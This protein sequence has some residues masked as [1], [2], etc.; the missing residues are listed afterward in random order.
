MIKIY[1]QRGTNRLDDE[2]TI[3]N[4][5]I[6][7]PTTDNPQKQV[8]RPSIFNFSD[9]DSDSDSD[10]N[11]DSGKITLK[12]VNGDHNEDNSSDKGNSDSDSE[13]DEKSPFCIK[14][15]GNIINKSRILERY[16]MIQNNNNL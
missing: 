9:S 15:Q 12:S 8:K 16:R 10:H 11:F 2:D 1:T 5:S 4:T 3:R 7:L 14:T 6:S 13:V